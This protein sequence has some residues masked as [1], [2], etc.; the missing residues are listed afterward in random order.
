VAVALG[1]EHTLG[2]FQGPLGQD[3]AP[4]VELIPQRRTLNQLHHN[5]GNRNPRQPDRSSEGSRLREVRLPVGRALT[6][7]PRRLGTLNAPS[8]MLPADASLARTRPSRQ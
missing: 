6:T 8:A 4:V 7:T 2:E 3:L 5:V 1:I